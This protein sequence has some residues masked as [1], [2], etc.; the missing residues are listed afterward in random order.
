VEKGDA[1]ATLSGKRCMLTVFATEGDGGTD[2]V[3]VGLNGYAYQIPR[4]EAWEVPAEVAQII[5]DAKVT[6]IT[7]AANGTSKE[8]VI[9]RFAHQI[10]PV[11]A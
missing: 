11:A 3:F 1:D 7:T 4:D 6:S 2:A 5:A 9:P 8:R 10:S